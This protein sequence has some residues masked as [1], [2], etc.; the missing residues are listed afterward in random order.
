MG[1]PFALVPIGAGAITTSPRIASKVARAIG[2]VGRLGNYP[3]PI[4]KY[5]VKPVT[6]TI[7]HPAV[8]NLG[9]QVGSAMYTDERPGRKAGGR[10]GTSHEDAADR[11][12]NAAERAKK[13]I[14]RGTESLLDTPDDHVATALAI[15][16]RSI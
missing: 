2:R 14:S 11:L 12:V 10:V 15:A 16:N 4:K 9:S 3:E 5:F 6:G 13:E 1:H 8:T 7:T